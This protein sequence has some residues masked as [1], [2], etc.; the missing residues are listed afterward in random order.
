MSLNL[1][2][3]ILANIMPNIMAH[4]LTESVTYAVS[5]LLFSKL[6]PMIML[7]PLRM[8]SLH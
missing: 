2:K 5:F 3:A 6:I 7:K 4:L 8:Y 1:M